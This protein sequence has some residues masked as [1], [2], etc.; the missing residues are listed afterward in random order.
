[1]HSLNK[2]PIYRRIL[3]KFSGEALLGDRQFGID[4]KVINFI[5][6]E[7]KEVADLGIQVGIVMG[8]GNIFRGS[9]AEKTGMD[10]VVADYAG[11]LATVIN[12]L[13]LEEALNKKGAAVRLQTALQM[14]QVAEP[15]IV[16]KALRHLEKN[17]VV[18]FA[19][20]TGNPYFTTDSGAALK[21]AE[22][23]ADAILKA[24]HQADGIYDKDP[25]IYKDAKKYKTLSYQEALEKRLKVMDST[26]FALCM[27]Y[28]IPIIVFNLNHG[29][30]IKK[31]VTGESVGTKVS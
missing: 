22:I 28:K 8:G 20:G 2:K 17:R 1:V 30:N 23:K 5:A 15:Y 13:V 3:V 10:R 16:K 11:M 29:G 18:I 9:V 31:I 24:T 26:A 12:G 19:A 27:D 25:L 7:V 6:Q 14:N 21:A 4:P